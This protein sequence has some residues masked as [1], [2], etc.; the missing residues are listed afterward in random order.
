MVLFITN[1]ILA[2]INAI[3][4][5]NSRQT[6]RVMDS[7]PFKVNP[8]YKVIYPFLTAYDSVTATAMLDQLIKVLFIYLFCLTT[9]HH[10]ILFLYYRIPGL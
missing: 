5:L 10:L 1:T 4:I 7:L 2:P 3:D 6:V 8:N 9:E